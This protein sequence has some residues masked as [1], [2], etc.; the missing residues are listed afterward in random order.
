[1]DHGAER[2]GRVDRVEL[3]PQLPA[4]GRLAQQQVLGAVRVAQMV[5]DQGAE[6]VVTA[7]NQDGAILMAMFIMGSSKKAIS[8]HQLHRMLGVTYKTAG[9]CPTASDT[10]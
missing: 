3:G 8:S 4:I 7:R 1:V 9:S 6:A 5:R 2:V 10:R